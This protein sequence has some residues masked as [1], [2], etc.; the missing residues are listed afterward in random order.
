ME[1]RWCRQ[2]AVGMVLAPM[3]WLVPGCGADGAPEAGSRGASTGGAPPTGGAR[4]GAVLATEASG[5]LRRG[6]AGGDPHAGD[7]FWGEGADTIAG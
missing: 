1:S 7:L 6:L 4:C 2:L 3:L 5:Q